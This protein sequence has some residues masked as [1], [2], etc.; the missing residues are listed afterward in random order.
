MS[1][2]ALRVGRSVDNQNSGPVTSLC[3]SRAGLMQEQMCL[4][5][6]LFLPL[7]TLSEGAGK[8]GFLLTASEPGSC[9]ASAHH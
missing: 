2:G 3:F 7:E 4:P 1:Q 9:S 8:A 5:W 6:T